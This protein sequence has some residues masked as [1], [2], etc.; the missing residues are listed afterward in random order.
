MMSFRAF[1][2][3]ISYRL[4][5]CMTRVGNSCEIETYWRSFQH[6]G[7]YNYSLRKIARKQMTKGLQKLLK[8]LR[9]NCI[10]FVCVHFPYLFS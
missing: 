7:N 6:F 3:A 8:R 5:D 1:W 4:A 10:V 9:E 2:V